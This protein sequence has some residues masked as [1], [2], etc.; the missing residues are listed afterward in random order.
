M[1]PFNLEEYIANPSKKVVTRD[2]KNVR[3]I[4]TDRK[5]SGGNDKYPVIALIKKQEDNEVHLDFSKDG[6]YRKDVE[7]WCDLFFAPERKEGWVNIYKNIVNDRVSSMMAYKTK[8]EAIK[9]IF[10][11][12]CYIDTIKIEWEE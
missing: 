3:I 9:S 6:K 1:K 12:D 4:C 10:N 7:S 8:E 2:G 5:N 11:Q